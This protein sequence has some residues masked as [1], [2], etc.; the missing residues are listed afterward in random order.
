[1]EKYPA[2]LDF[3]HV[4]AGA[5]GL[6]GLEIKVPDAVRRGTTVEMSCDYD[7]EGALLYSIKWYKDDQEFFSYVPKEAP[8]SRVYHVDGI[9]VDVSRTLETINMRE[10]EKIFNDGKI[11]ACLR[12]VGGWS[13]CFL[14]HGEDLR[15]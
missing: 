8:P 15:N 2:K 4:F 5:S 6:R 12:L 14:G 9:F 3:I 7:L 1:L 13:A 11:G 10:K